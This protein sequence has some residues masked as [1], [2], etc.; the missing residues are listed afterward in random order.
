LIRLG[1]GQSPLLGR[2]SGELVAYAGRLT[3][4]ML[5]SETTLR[6]KFPG[7]FSRDEVLY[8]L[9]RVTEGDWMEVIVESFWE[10]SH[11]SAP[12]SS[13]AWR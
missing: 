8:N 6:W 5:I 11:V 13:T 10:C 12:G 2:D 7:G 3:D 9:H 4:D 1:G